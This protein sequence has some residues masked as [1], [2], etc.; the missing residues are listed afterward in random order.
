MTVAGGMLEAIG[1]P[2]RHLEGR[3]RVSALWMKGQ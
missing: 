3:P 1:A 2:R